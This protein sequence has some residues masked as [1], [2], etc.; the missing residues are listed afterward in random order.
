M[1]VE[2]SQLFPMQVHASTLGSTLKDLRVLHGC[3]HRRM[4]ELLQCSKTMLRMYET[5]GA[6]IPSDRMIKYCKEIGLSVV[7]ID[8]ELPAPTTHRELILP[9]DNRD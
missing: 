7:L 3:Q 8:W 2:R 9:H 4:V 6:A 1:A 5:D